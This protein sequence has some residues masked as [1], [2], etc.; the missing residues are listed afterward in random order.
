LQ[1][2]D[3]VAFPGSPDY[4]QQH[5]LTHVG[6]VVSADGPQAWVES[7][8][9]LMTHPVI[10]RLEMTPLL[11]GSDVFVARPK[12]HLAVEPSRETIAEAGYRIPSAPPSPDDLLRTAIRLAA[13]LPTRD[14][15]WIHENF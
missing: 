15:S 11:Y 5:G 10:H 4:F 1:V 6:R 13:A 2:N 9:G 14:L 3:I 7:Q 8:W 12:G